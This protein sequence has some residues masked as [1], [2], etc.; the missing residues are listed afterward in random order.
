MELYMLNNFF[1]IAAKGVGR[2]R[3]VIYHPDSAQNEIEK[4]LVTSIYDNI[5]IS[6]K[7][8]SFSLDVHKNIEEV[9]T[10]IKKIYDTV[11]HSQ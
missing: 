5:E 9:V 4:F 2:Y 8:I 11:S 6:K 7:I 3:V 10:N 1:I